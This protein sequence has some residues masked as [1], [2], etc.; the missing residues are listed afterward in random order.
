MN[1]DAT[2]GYRYL[3][4]WVLASIVQFATYRFCERFFTR[5]LDPTGRQYDQMTQAARSGK[6]N[7]V[8]GSSRSATSKETEMKLTY[9]A[10][11]SLTELHSDYEDWLLRQGLVPWLRTRPKRRQYFLFVLPVPIMAT[12]SFTARVCICSQSRKNLR[13]GLI[14]K[15][16]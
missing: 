5:K 16:L 9:V 14:P 6:V 12:I 15:I 10:R 3:D 7:I 11:A 1:F 4:S 13:N 2:A 8:E